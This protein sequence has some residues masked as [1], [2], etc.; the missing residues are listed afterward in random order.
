M[1]TIAAC[2]IVS[3]NYLPFA[4]TLADSFMKHHKDA[5][6]FVLLVDKI[7]G[8]FD[9]SKEKFQLIEVDELDNIEHKEQMF[10]KY[11]TVELNTAVK[12]FFLE[13]IF[14]HYP[15]EQCFI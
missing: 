8:Y 5:S 2:T 15:V 7:D 3:K 13:Y 4:R 9:P 12:P 14:K 10:F 6:C 1:N 11:N